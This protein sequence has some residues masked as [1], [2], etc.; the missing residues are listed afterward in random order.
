MGVWKY[1]IAIGALFGLL[2]LITVEIRVNYRRIGKDDL[3]VIHIST[4]R[5]MVGFKMEM[6]SL[7]FINNWLKPMVHLAVELESSGGKTLLKKR[8]TVDPQ[9]IEWLRVPRL[10]RLAGRV[11]NRFRPAITYFIRHL[12]I[13]Q[14]KWRT[15]FGLD[16]AAQ[17]GLGIGTLWGLKGLVYARLK[18]NTLK[19]G[20]KPQVQVIPSFH[21]SAFATDFDCI[22]AIRTGHIIITGINFLSCIFFRRKRAVG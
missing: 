9:D 22:F 21:Q 17:T 15:R 18:N 6:S 1:I 5:R 12:R 2:A 7:H 19:T 11:Y 16:N 20:V 10:V 13:N 14:F 8:R 3:F 4:F